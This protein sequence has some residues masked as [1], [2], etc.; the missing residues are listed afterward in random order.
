MKASALRIFG[1][2][3]LLAGAAWGLSACGTPAGSPDTSNSAQAQAVTP[4]PSATPTPSPTQ[5]K[6]YTSEELTALVAQ[7]KDAQGKPLTVM[8]GPELKKSIDQTKSLL[9]SIAVEPAECAPLALGGQAASTDGV[10][11]GVGVAQDAATG[12]TTGVSLAS[13]ADPE[14][15]QRGLV[16]SENLGNCAALSF[17]VAGTKAD[18]KL[19]KLSGVG[20]TPGAIAYRSDTALADGRKQST[21]TAQAVRNGVLITVS[22]A[23]G[24]SEADAVS[25]AGAMLDN[26]AAVIK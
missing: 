3:A 21:I 23:G 5:A 2:A 25:R 19:T 9:A 13:G 15:L 12:A 26:A 24:A 18:L 1:S 7:L 11:I 17:T 10:A 6:A 22:A 14:V 8:A 20:T 16:K 4:V